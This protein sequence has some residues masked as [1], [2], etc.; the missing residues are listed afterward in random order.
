MEDVNPTVLY[1]DPCCPGSIAPQWGLVAV[2]RAA[3]GAGGQCGAGGE[4]PGRWLEWIK[5]KFPSLGFWVFF[6]PHFPGGTRM[7]VG[8][9]WEIPAFIVEL[10]NVLEVV[11][12]QRRGDIF[13]ALFTVAS[14]DRQ[15]WRAVH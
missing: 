9:R 5:D 6:S 14:F 12:G 1:S 15:K 8:G 11:R 4:E 7:D 3:Q 2:L 10:L 13:L